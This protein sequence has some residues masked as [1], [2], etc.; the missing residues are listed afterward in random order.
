MTAG[1]LTL[2]LLEPTYA[3]ITRI[4]L[5]FRVANGRAGEL[6]S[7]RWQA[8]S[9]LSQALLGKEGS[10]TDPDVQHSV[11]LRGAITEA[12]PSV[13][14]SLVFRSCHIHTHLGL[15]HYI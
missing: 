12:H 11:A 10:G 8:A 7:F 3:I 1:R 14:G 4:K 15:G 9:S 5:S 6:C 2:Q 13:L